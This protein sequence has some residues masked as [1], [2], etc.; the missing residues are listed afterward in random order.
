VGGQELGAAAPAHLPGQ[1]GV[2]GQA[3]DRLDQRAGFAE[4]DR[5]PA[6]GVAD[7]VGRLAVLRAHE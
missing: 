7:R 2:G 3:P 4:A 5:Q 6:A 1:L